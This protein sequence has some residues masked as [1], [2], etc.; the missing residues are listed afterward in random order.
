MTAQVLA[1]PGPAPARRSRP[2]THW[3][4]VA[5]FTASVLMLVVYAQ[6]WE[7]FLPDKGV[8]ALG[9]GLARAMFFP[10]YAL[11]LGLISLRPGAALK[12]LAGQPFLL[13]LLAICAASVAWSVTPDETPR[14]VVGLILTTACGV[15]IGSRWRW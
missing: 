6:P 5:A 14:R 3:L 4:D 9:S 12:G 15:A 13:V 11:G 1:W 7:G 8:S 10:M 2:R